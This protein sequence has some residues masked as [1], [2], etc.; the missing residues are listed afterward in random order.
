MSKTSKRPVIRIPTLEEDRA[1][2]EAAKGDPDAQP[3]TSRQLRQMVPLAQV[4][5]RLRSGHAKQLISMLYSPEVIAYFRS[6]GE[7]WQS[8]MDDVLKDYVEQATKS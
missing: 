1:L 7:G 8:R 2:V 4:S 3:L 5:D 6:T